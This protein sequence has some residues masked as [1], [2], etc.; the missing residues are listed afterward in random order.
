MDR[1]KELNKTDTRIVID[2]K[3]KMKKTK[4]ITDELRY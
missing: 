3:T 2:K 4:K 1:K